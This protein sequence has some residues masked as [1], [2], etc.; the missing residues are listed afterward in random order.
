MP[1][2][3]DYDK[4]SNMN[5]KQLLNALINAENKKQKIKQDLNEKIK[6]TTELIKFLKTK[7][8]KSLNEP[9]SYTL[10]QAPS[11]KKI[12]AYFE[13]LP[14]A[15]QDKIIAEVRAEMGLNVWNYPKTHSR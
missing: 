10:A 15:E 4:Y 9:K 6:H 2:T 7:L 5:K 1:A 14:Q 12:N 8:K 13:K 3:I 11:I